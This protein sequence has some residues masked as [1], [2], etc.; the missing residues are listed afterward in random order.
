MMLLS[1]NFDSFEVKTI[2][3][4]DTSTQIAMET[5]RNLLR[6]ELVHRKRSN[7]LILLG[8]L[9]SRS[10]EL[11]DSVVVLAVELQLEGCHEVFA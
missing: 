4:K 7:L 5:I 8:L 10:E 9:P 3:S 1:G 11:R 6:N 2:C